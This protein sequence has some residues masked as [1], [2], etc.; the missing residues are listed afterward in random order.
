MVVML[1]NPLTCCLL[2]QGDSY[3][4][5]KI[6]NQSLF[7][8]G[9]AKDMCGQEASELVYRIPKFKYGVPLQQAQGKKGTLRKVQRKAHHSAKDNA[10]QRSTR[11]L[12][13]QQV[14]NLQRGLEI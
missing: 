10:N 9:N 4:E 2:V 6:L 12:H 13:C 5:L 1:L 11:H 14:A 7:A 8:Q 3:E